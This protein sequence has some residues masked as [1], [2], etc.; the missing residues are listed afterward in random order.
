MNEKDIRRPVSIRLFV[1]ALLAMVL[2]AAVAFA[3]SAQATTPAAAS[4]GSGEIARIIGD[5]A[6]AVVRLLIGAGVA[7]FMIGVARGAFDGVLASVLGAPGAAGVGLLR[8]VGIAGAFV[9]MLVSLGLSRSLVDLLVRQFVDQGA[10]T[11]PVPRQAE[12]YAPGVD[13]GLQGLAGVIG[14]VLRIVLFLIGAWFLVGMLVALINGEIQLATGSPGALAR[15]VERLMTSLVLLVI[16][17]STP[18]L[19]GELARAIEGVG[20]IASGG[21]AIHLYGVVFAIVIDILLAIFVGVL[22]IAAVGSGFMVQAGMA[23]G[24]PQG[25]GVGV[26]RV[27]TAFAIAVVG[28]GVIGLANRLLVSLLS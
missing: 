15:L 1:A 16:G 27:T 23:L 6:V 21:D 25:M 9:L 28:F 14:E 10:L 8:T 3:A 2:L 24:L 18:S 4:D 7:V 12:V 13:Q 17:A 19:T 11:P 26:A 20:S 22:I 5:V